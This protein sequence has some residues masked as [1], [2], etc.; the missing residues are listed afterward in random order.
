MGNFAN[1]KKM[2]YE[3]IVHYTNGPVV[4]NLNYG[5]LRYH[6]LGV[7]TVYIFLEDKNSLGKENVC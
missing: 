3:S 6:L 2:F 5:P 4:L 1:K 7:S